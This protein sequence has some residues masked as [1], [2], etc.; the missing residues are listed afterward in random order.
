MRRE[1]GGRRRLIVAGLVAVAV[2]SIGSRLE[3]LGRRT[4][5]ARR[6]FK[7]DHAGIVH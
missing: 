1:S 3:E 5:G 7:V 4:H 2:R 6:H